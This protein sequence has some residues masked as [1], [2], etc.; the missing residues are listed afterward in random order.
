MPFAEHPVQVVDL[1]L[2]AAGRQPLAVTLQRLAADVHGGHGAPHGPLA[3]VVDTGEGG[4]ALLA[5]LLALPASD[6]R[7]DQH[8]ER[9]LAGLLIRGDVIGEHPLEHADLG[10]G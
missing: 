10:R 5:V 9:V 7:V 4:G 8:P 6:D 3:G 1:V 2:D